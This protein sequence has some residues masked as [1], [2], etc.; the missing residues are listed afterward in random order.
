LSYMW[1]MNCILDI[2]NFWA[3]IYLSVSAYHVCSFGLGYL[4]QD[5]TF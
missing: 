4:S 3:N 2:L 1:S 5:D